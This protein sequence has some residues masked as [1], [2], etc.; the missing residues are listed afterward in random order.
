MS[1]QRKPN[2]R[3]VKVFEFVHKDSSK[4]IITFNIHVFIVCMHTQC[5][6]QSRVIECGYY[7][8][9]LMHDIILSRSTSVIDIV[10]I[11]VLKLSSCNLS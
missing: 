9:R 5:L 7:V 6:K 1:N 3:V 10:S 8:M 2:W 4:L 11:Q